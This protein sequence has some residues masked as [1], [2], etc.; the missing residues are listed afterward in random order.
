MPRLNKEQILKTDDS[1]LTKKQLENKKKWLAMAKSKEIDSAP[2]PTYGKKE[3]FTT[4]PESTLKNKTEEINQDFQK[5][6]VNEDGDGNIKDA[7]TPETWEEEK[8]RGITINTSNDESEKVK[9]AD[10]SPGKE[11]GIMMIDTALPLN[12]QLSAVQRIA[13]LLEID[14]TDNLVKFLGSDENSKKIQEAISTTINEGVFSSDSKAAEVAY[15][16]DL[17]ES[18][19]E[20]IK[21]H[22]VLLDLMGKTFEKTMDLGVKNGYL[23]AKN[24]F[25]KALFHLGEVSP[26]KVAKNIREIPTRKDTADE[27]ELAKKIREFELYDE[28]TKINLFRKSLHVAIIATEDIKALTPET[29]QEATC[30]TNAWVHLNEMR[31]ALGNKLSKLRP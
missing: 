6:T 20:I 10:V 12:E 23:F 30:Y 5:E 2:T 4:E 15:Y 7:L 26:Y 25:G 27:K 21:Q 8:E 29:W 1:Q 3:D 22:R 18:K 31:F 16:K 17:M 9:A 11:K 13:E 14:N 28:L 19:I 24:W